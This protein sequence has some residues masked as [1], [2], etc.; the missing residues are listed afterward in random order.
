MEKGARAP[1]SRTDTPTPPTPPYAWLLT[2]IVVVGGH[3]R[4]D[5]VNRRERGGAGKDAVAPD[6]TGEALAGIGAVK[7]VKGH[8]VRV[9]GTVAAGDGHDA[10][11]R[12][13]LARPTGRHT[14]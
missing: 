12:A 14:V 13:I 5:A 8:G 3:G 9:E 10:E 4:A 7:G 6:G 1:H 2:N 11:A